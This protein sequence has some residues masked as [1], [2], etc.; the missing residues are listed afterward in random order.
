MDLLPLSRS[1]CRGRHRSG[2][3]PSPKLDLEPRNM[4]HERWACGVDECR[5]AC[6]M[7]LRIGAPRS[8][9]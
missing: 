8:S 6:A 5:R 1:D 2:F 7:L 4:T 9:L 3:R